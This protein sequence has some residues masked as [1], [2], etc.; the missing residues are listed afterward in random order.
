MLRLSSAD[1]AKQSESVILEPLLELLLLQIADIE[2]TQRFV[3]K[4]RVVLKM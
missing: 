2:G 4:K 3:L 1:V